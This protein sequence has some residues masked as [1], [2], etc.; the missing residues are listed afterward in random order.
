LKFFEFGFHLLLVVSCQL[1]VA[2]EKQVIVC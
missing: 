2:S 1:S